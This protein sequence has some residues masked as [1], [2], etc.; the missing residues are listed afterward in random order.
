M[1]GAACRTFRKMELE[2]LQLDFQCAGLRFAKGQFLA[3]SVLARPDEGAGFRERR[4]ATILETEILAWLARHQAQMVDLLRDLVN[5]DSGTYDKAGVDAAGAVLTAF[6]RQHGLSV[7]THPHHMFGDGIS[8]H[9]P[10]RD[11]GSA[12]PILLLGHRDTVFPKGE[13]MRRPFTIRD[14]RG[15][16]PGVADMKSGLVIEAFVMAAF[17]AAGGISVPLTM[18]TTSDEEIA[19][20]SSRDLIQ[21]YARQARAV[22][23][24][25]PSR[26]SSDPARG[27][28]NRTQVITRGRKGGVFMKVEVTGK[29]AHSGARYEEGRSAILD[30]AQKVAPLHGL[31]D[32]AAGITVN[33]G[34]IGGGQTVNTIAPSAWA[35]IDL[36]YVEPAQR[37]TL[38]EAIRS[39]VETPAVEGTSAKLAIVGEFLP[40]TQSDD[41]QRLLE[42]F[43]SAAARLGV[44]VTSQFSGGCAD[45]GLTA[46]VG[47][48]TLCSVGPAGGAGHTPEEFVIL[49]S[50]LPSAQ[51]LALAVLETAAAFR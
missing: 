51:T 33:V 43:T 18:L 21:T 17:A 32:L 36:R 9:L 30:L 44:E 39:I 2:F 4:M 8:G 40:L 28:N 16:G 5:A 11:G 1:D 14:G 49:D 26:E 45:S 3:G 7:Q 23:N 25:E 27:G 22:F 12:R 50:M 20:P 37:A 47:C 29:A 31:T 41:S 15:Y 34:L 19:S 48:P 46:A 38:V 6:W 42:I 13:P 10:A 35:E 24:A